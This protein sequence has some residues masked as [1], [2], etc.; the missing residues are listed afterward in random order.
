MPVGCIHE[1][2]LIAYYLRCGGEFCQVF[3]LCGY[4][5][6]VDV[7]LVL[8]NYGSRAFILSIRLQQGLKGY[9]DLVHCLR[10]NFITYAFP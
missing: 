4:N 8:Q 2:S 1:P 10:N 6:P 9:F 3:R 5:Y 7:F